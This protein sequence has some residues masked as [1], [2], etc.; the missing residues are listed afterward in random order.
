MNKTVSVVMAIYNGDKFINE[1][2]DSILCQTYLP[3]EVIIVNDASKDNSLAVVSDYKNKYG[4]KLEFIIINNSTNLGVI[5]S[6]EE[7][8]KL[9]S[10]QY[11]ALCDQDDVWFTNKIE[12]LVQNIN[13]NYLIY[14][15]AIVTDQHLN[16]IS[17]SNLAKHEC[18]ITYS[19]WQDYLYGNNVTGC[20][21]MFDRILL[22]Y[23]PFPET[24]LMFHDWYLA[25]TAAF[26]NKI[27]RFPVPLMYYRQHTANAS[28]SYHN[29]NYIKFR[30][31]SLTFAKDFTTL[32][33]SIIS[34]KHKAISNEIELS[35]QYY[36]ALSH[37]KYPNPKLL[38]HLIKKFTIRKFLWF[39][40]M[41]ML[42]EKF[43]EIN[44]TLSKKIK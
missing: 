27:K 20:T 35:I 16:I 32:K 30:D 7:G 31:D 34:T 43:A 38:I 26:F 25:I 33:N 15:D 2:L 36:L 8:I 19:A 3:T 21:V 13:D 39:M 5:K 24:K 9:A 18:G 28:V 6:F 44:Y 23:L 11:I 22:E 10:S 41:A 12:S 14:S 29:V 1:Q 42:S 40:R 37:K 4:H 17:N